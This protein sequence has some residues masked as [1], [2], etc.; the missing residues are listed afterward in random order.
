MKKR[1]RKKIFFPRSV[2]QTGS[3]H[4]HT[5][6]SS[7][8]AVRK[9]DLWK[10]YFIHATFIIIIIQKFWRFFLRIRLSPWQGE[11]GT[12]DILYP[13]VS[14]Y[15]YLRLETSAQIRA[16]FVIDKLAVP[17]QRCSSHLFFVL[18]IPLGTMPL[19]HRTSTQNRLREMEEGVLATQ[20]HS[21]A[22][23]RHSVMTTTLSMWPCRFGIWDQLHLW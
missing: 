14:T 2:S 8:D 16:N 13:W 10:V 1:E 12:R 19:S 23:C 15:K 21:L 4:I 6:T 5:K 20:G 17:L 11:S 18:P 22:P 7:T 9:T 3:K